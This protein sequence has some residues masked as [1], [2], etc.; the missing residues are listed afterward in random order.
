[1]LT[2]LTVHDLLIL[3]GSM[4]W[5]IYIVRIMMLSVTVSSLRNDEIG[6]LPFLNVWEA[7]PHVSRTYS[8]QGACY[9]KV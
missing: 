4:Y 6:I 2:M 5:V 8:K 1:M 9:K 7:H 3:E